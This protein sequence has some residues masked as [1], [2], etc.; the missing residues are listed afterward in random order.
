MIRRTNTAALSKLLVLSP[1]ALII[2]WNHT[3][4]KSKFPFN[5]NNG[6][7]FSVPQ[8]VLCF[9]LCGRYWSGAPR[10]LLS[11]NYSR[12]A[13]AT[14]VSETVLLR[15]HITEHT[16]RDFQSGCVEN[17]IDDAFGVGSASND[18]RVSTR[19]TR[20]HIARSPIN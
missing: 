8:Q 5:S 6:F 19:A 20:L 3:T 15:P 7:K 9:M 13:R 16:P 17:A 2:R 11:V 14:C 4:L 12:D 10:D 1:N 18:A